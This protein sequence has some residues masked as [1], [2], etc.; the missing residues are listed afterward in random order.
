MKS[1]VISSSVIA[2]FNK[3]NAKDVY[4]R[5][6]NILKKENIKT[7]LLKK[8][9]PPYFLS[10]DDIKKMQRY[11]KGLD[12]IFVIGGDGT[13][14]N[15]ARVASI[16][17]IPLLGINL[18]KLGFLSC[19]NIEDLE[20]KIKQVIQNNYKISPR[21]MLDAYVY[22]S[23]LRNKEVYQ[24]LNDVVITRESCARMLNLEVSVDGTVLHVYKGDGMI[25]ST[26]TGSTAYCLAAGG[27][28]VS[29]NIGVMV[30]V[31]ICPHTLSS[32]PLVVS[33]NQEVKVRVVSAHNDI[34]VT[35][36]GQIAGKLDLF[37]Y[38]IIK[39]SQ[40]I[41][42]MVVFKDYNFYEHLQK[43]LAGRWKV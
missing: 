17:N 15:A 40:N 13:F 30:I 21:L 39:R 8:L 34:V 5:L 26:P 4:K 29:P 43:K 18:G 35:V 32:R 2:D 41:T 14:L 22:R 1:D 16:Y 28:V 9:S 7:R 6:I 24:A 20:K 25:I 23:N 36:D 10:I 42:R 37:D 11:F 19:I 27:P 38:V 3:K 12:L 31:P 33:C